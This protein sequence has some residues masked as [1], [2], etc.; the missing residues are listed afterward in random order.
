MFFLVVA[1]VLAFMG[2]VAYRRIL[3]AYF[4]ESD[5]PLNNFVLSENSLE[6]YYEKQN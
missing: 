3:T 2:M 6:G 1:F 5:W 4:K